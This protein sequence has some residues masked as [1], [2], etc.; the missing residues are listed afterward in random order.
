MVQYNL[1]LITMT[2]KVSKLNTND[3][4]VLL[5]YFININN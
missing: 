1:N 5:E 3:N 2:D 4:K